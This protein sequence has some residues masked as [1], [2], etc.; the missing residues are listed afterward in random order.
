MKYLGWAAIATVY[1]LTLATQLPHIYDVYSALERSEHRILGVDTAL[2]ASVAFEA[3][4]AIFT[5][6]TIINRKS[7]RSRWT[8]WGLVGFL[9]LSALANVSYY[10]DL[11]I[12]DAILMPAALV[13]AIPLALWLYAEEFGAEARAE[14]R[15][16]RKSAPVIDKPALTKERPVATL[17][18][19]RRIAADSNGDLRELDAIGVKAALE[20][21][22]Y[23][24][25]R[26]EST[27]RGWAKAIN[28]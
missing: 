8:Y 3:S 23:K 12:V 14:A 20:E 13:C 21:R 7:E 24:V 5:L 25:T 4:V 15:S 18:D 27:L 22:G 16:R 19:W 26:A 28:D 17:D 1:L 2:G 6:R 10:F 11:Q 9:C